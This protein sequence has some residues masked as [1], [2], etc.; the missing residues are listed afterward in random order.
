M[1]QSFYNLNHIVCIDV[2]RNRLYPFY[3]TKKKGF[4]W[5]KLF[6]IIPII[7]LY[8]KENVYY[9]IVTRETLYRKDILSNE[10]L[11]I[12]KDGEVVYKPHV[13]L[14]FNGDDI[15]SYTGASCDRFFETQCEL[16]EYIN[17]FVK[18]LQALNIPIREL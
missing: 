12:N 2:Y 10:D 5:W 17:K 13:L 9:N 6:G 1:K 14:Y 7:K 16:D 15:R 4:Y 3:R 18:E 8:R 11:T